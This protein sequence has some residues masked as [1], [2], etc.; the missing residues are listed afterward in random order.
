LVYGFLRGVFL[1]VFW[2]IINMSMCHAWRAYI[3][4]TLAS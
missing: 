4:L 1:D 2:Y 3:P